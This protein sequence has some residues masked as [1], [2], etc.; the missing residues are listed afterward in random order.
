MSWGSVTSAAAPTPFALPSDLLLIRDP[1]AYPAFQA[2]GHNQSP[3]SEGYAP[4]DPLKGGWIG[5]S[6]EP[7][8]TFRCPKNHVERDSHPISTGN[9]ATSNRQQATIIPCIPTAQRAQDEKKQRH[10]TR[11]ITEI[12][13]LIRLASGVSDGSHRAPITDDVETF[14]DVHMCTCV[15]YVQ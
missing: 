12:W 10:I 4:P 2:S 9:S 11:D 13:K 3:H 7:A 5:L 8:I 15:Q 6:L 1:R 14:H